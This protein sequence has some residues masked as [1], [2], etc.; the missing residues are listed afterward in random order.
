MFAGHIDEIGVMVSYVDDDG[1]CH[2]ETIGGWDTQVFVGQRVLLLGGRGLVPGVVGKRAIHLQE[3]EDREKVSRTQDLWIDVGAR[4]RAEAE[5]LG[6]RIGDGGVIASTVQ[7][8]ANGRIVSRSLDNRMGAFVV[9]EALRLLAQDPPAASVT[10]VATTQEEIAWQTGGGARTAA[11]ALEA[12]VAIVVDV[13][14]ATDYPGMLKHRHGDVKLGGGPVLSRGS[15]VNPIVLDLLV[16]SAEA[17][18]MPYTLQAAP[19]YTGTD[20]DSIY[21]AHRGVAT[22]LVSVP[23]RYMHSPSEMVDLADLERAARLLAAFARRVSE[24]TDFVPR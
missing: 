22:G 5:A 24:A 11:V 19:K 8:F 16:A 1:F 3:K 9:L 15:A 17:E 18:G 4:T 12:E 2:F 23:N 7:E 14:H 20:A 10:A 13:T 21:T 6:L